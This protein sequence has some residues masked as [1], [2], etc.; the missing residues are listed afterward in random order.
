MSDNIKKFIIFLFLFAN[1]INAQEIKSDIYKFK[2]INEDF[3]S[4][5]HD[6]PII[7][8]NDNYFILD[9]D[10]YLTIRKNN[11]SEYAIII[12]N[13]LAE[14][15][16]L[17]TKFKLGPSKNNTSVGIIASA[18]KNFTKALVVEINKKGEYR[19]KQLNTNNYI[20]LS[21]KKRK[22]G[23]V[24]NKNINKENEYNILELIDNKNNITLKI[25]DKLIQTFDLKINKSGYYGLLLGKYAKAR[26]SY[27]YLNSDKAQPKVKKE[28]VKNNFSNNS[29]PLNKNEISNNNKEQNNNSKYLYKIEN[30][31][32]TIKGLTNKLNS[33]TEEHNKQLE[34][35]ELELKNSKNEIQK[36]ENLVKDIINKDGILS[37]E[38]EE[39]KK[40][41]AL[42][43]Q[44]AKVFKEKNNVLFKKN[45]DLNIELK[46]YQNNFTSLN[47][48][49]LKAQK[50]NIKKSDISLN[51][52]KEIK[53][54]KSK[55][56]RSNSI[57]K[58]IRSE[59]KNT[60]SLLNNLK[61]KLIESSKN[62]K[63]KNKLAN[64]Q[65]SKL[66][67][68]N[69][70]LNLKIEANISENAR[71]LSKYKNINVENKEK[72]SQLSL[73]INTKNMEISTHIKTNQY[74][75]EI[76]VYKDF[77][78]NGITPSTLIVTEK[79][80]P[81]IMEITNTDSSY[82]IQ[83]GVF[84]NPINNFKSLDKIWIEQSNNIYTFYHG[85]FINANDAT[86][87]LNKL[88]QLGYRNMHI[89]KKKNKTNVTK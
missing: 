72:I 46:E 83:L 28:I 32:V 80:P 87:K 25:N 78:L 30:L 13:S 53:D 10:E 66:E 40:D 5:N 42:S 19:I 64:S 48:K 16:Y 27:Y 52:Q 43:V 18:D 54:L 38:I 51:D 35:K 39:L 84:T 71:N 49:L 2:I 24:R 7:R 3:S 69:K 79:K 29:N 89:I 56:D 86:K 67:K 63:E 12:E 76:F 36:F 58:E 55:I 8:E 50:D 45:T 31:E 62:Q 22:N 9:E 70:Q 65:I 73:L 23:W 44:K 15:S 60:N 74:L 85:Q 33:K 82:T 14:N 37:L 77:E 21:G 41:L 20:Y 26:V 68:N 11:K 34:S 59:L 81:I 75:K 57:I 47:N 61:E 88:I 6:F 4:E 1:N 17:K